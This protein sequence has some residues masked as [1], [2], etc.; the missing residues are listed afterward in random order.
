[1]GFFAAMLRAEIMILIG[2][3][4]KL[5][6]LRSSLSGMQRVQRESSGKTTGS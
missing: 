1:M 4:Q 6:S 3:E 2:R 5:R